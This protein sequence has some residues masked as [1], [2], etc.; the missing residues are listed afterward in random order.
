MQ[1]TKRIFNDDPYQSEF[2]ATVLK[3]DGDKVWLDQTAFYPESG[4]QAGDTGYIDDFLVINTQYDADKN[5]VHQL[6][7]TADLLHIQ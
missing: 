1:A 5:I 6:D 3:V 2:A 7:Q 4:G